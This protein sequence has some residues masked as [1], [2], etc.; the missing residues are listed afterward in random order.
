M[1]KNILKDLPCRVGVTA[2]SVVA[3]LV[4]TRLRGRSLMVGVRNPWASLFCQDFCRLCLSAGS[5]FFPPRK[6][7]ISRVQRQKSLSNRIRDSQMDIDF[8]R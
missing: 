1:K 4:L 7:Q 8:S 5:I 3:P 6:N 2:H